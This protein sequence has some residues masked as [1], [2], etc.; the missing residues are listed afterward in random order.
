M[1]PPPQGFGNSLSSSLPPRV[2]ASGR[3]LLR[4]ERLHVHPVRYWSTSTHISSGQSNCHSI[5]GNTSN[6]GVLLAAETILDSAAHEGVSGLWFLFF[7]GVP[8]LI[9]CVVLNSTKI[10]HFTHTTVRITSN[11]Y[12]LITRN[13]TWRS[14][15]QIIC[16]PSHFN[17]LETGE[18]VETDPIEMSCGRIPSLEARVETHHNKHPVTYKIELGPFYFAR[19]LDKR[20]LEWLTEEIN[21]FLRVTR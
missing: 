14:F 19:G 1:P 17:D 11:T 21:R 20:E 12:C 7:I 3:F 5:H 9:I 15:L 2:A 13:I 6:L 18:V 8:L 10:E 4:L 16:N